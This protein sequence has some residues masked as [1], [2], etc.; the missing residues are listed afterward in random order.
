M[1][2]EP[3]PA[4]Q[5][6]DMFD[7]ATEVDRLERIR[8][9]AIAE[10]EKSD[11]WA[12][13]NRKEACRVGMRAVIAAIFQ[14]EAVAEIIH[15]T[16]AVS[17]MVLTTA[18]MALGIGTHPVFAATPP[19]PVRVADFFGIP[20]EEI[21][22]PDLSTVVTDWIEAGDLKEGDTFEVEGWATVERFTVR[23]TDDDFGWER[24][25]ATT[26]PGGDPP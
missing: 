10:W 18:G 21:G 11:N 16:D 1:N 9:N 12:G 20:G 15:S 14:G 6:G 26:A 8:Q 2:N 22:G 13:I 4:E 3:H 5:R 23:V 25:Q 19:A 17:R 24:V 7:E